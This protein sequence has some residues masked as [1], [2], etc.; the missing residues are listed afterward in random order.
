MFAEHGRWDVPLAAWFAPLLL[1]RFGRD[2]RPWRAVGL[3]WLATAA[4]A[5]FWLWE[6]GVS[7][8]FAFGLLL[9]TIFTLPFVADRFVVPRLA[10]RPFLATLVFPATWVAAEYVTSLTSPTGDIFG[11]L[12][13]TQHGDLPLLQVA[14]VTGSFGVTFLIAWFA[15]VA[16]HAWEQRGTIRRALRTVVTYAVVLAVVLAGGA[17]RLAVTSP[18]ADTVRMA[19]IAPTRAVADTRDRRAEAATLP[20]LA[21]H[22]ARARDIYGPVN[23]DLLARTHREAWAGAKVVIWPEAA[24]RVHQDDRDALLRRIGRAARRD[25]VYIELGMGVVTRQAP[26]GRNQAVLVDP[27]GHV[28]WTYQKAHPVP[29]M[30]EFPAGDGR[31]PTA[32]TPYGTLANVICFDADFPALT[33]QA[34]AKGADV[35]FVPASDW[36]EFGKVHTE[37]AEL[38]TIENGYSLFREDGHGLTAAYDPQGRKLAATD[39]FRTEHQVTVADVPIHGTPTVYGTIGDVFAWTTIA[40]LLALLGYAFTRR[41]RQATPA[42]PRSAHAAAPPPSPVVHR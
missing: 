9:S 3:V 13:V 21:R 6:S 23:A 15:T 11:S 18:T 8:L 41:R 12:A 27:D 36:P 42:T 4:A 2:T 26:Y 14:S 19:G 39:Y 30:E 31:G 10:G 33:H 7:P 5:Q 34:A 24:V 20:V 16:N 35:L 1:I 28:R 22:P 29:G 25:H 40:G 32:R 38:R 37:K 17:V